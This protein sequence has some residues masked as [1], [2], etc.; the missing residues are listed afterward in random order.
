MTP[1]KTICR[2]FL[3]SIIQAM[4]LATCFAASGENNYVTVSCSTP[5]VTGVV[6][7]DDVN[8]HIATK[9]VAMD[10]EAN[11]TVAPKPGYEL[12]SPKGGTF[13]NLAIGSAVSYEVKAIEAGES[14]ASGSIVLYKVDVEIDGV[15]EDKEETE[16]A[17]VSDKDSGDI[18]KQR[19]DSLLSGDGGGGGHQR[20]L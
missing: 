17:Y 5:G 3:T 12:V 1:D 7:V 11:G 2:F 18:H 15:G 14:G 13:E 6:S 16:G 9:D 10:F 20:V 8:F 4:L 19:N